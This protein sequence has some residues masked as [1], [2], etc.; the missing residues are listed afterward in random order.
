MELLIILGVVIALLLII[1]VEIPTILM[2]FMVLLFLTLLLM[3]VFF[4]YCLFMMVGTKKCTGV[5]TKTGKSPKYKYNCAYYMIDGQEYYNI[6]PCEVILKKHIYS[7]GKEYKVRLNK[8]KGIVF[9]PNAYACVIAG[10]LLTA[11]S[12]IMVAMMFR[13]MFLR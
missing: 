13:I 7:T 9:D 4:L 6:F 11:A 10:S 2:G 1:G 12:L 5:L 8:K 3:I